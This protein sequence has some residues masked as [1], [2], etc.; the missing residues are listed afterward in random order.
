MEVV[1]E[2]GNLLAGRFDIAQVSASQRPLALIATREMG[3]TSGLY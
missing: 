3:C 1:V 2:D